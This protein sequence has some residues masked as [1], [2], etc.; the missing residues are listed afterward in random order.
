MLGSRFVMN[1]EMFLNKKLATKYYA[2]IEC[3]VEN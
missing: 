2:N 1:G 3:Y